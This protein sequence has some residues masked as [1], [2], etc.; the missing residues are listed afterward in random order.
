MMTKYTLFTLFA[1]F[2]LLVSCTDGVDD[3]KKT[4]PIGKTGDVSITAN[5]AVWT[6]YSLEQGKTVGTSAFGDSSADSEWRQRT[7]WDIA[8]CGDLIRTNSGMSGTGNGGIQVVSDD[9]N[10]LQNV[11]QSGYIIDHFE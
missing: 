4:S 2:T 10:Q 9:Y 5:D 8:V 1:A 3:G 11:P 6:Y 7:D